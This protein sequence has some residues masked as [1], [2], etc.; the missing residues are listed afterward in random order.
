MSK[1]KTY[2]LANQVPKWAEEMI[3][4][5]YTWE[6][7]RSPWKKR[8]FFISMPCET[9]AAPLFALG[10]L[11][12]DLE[13]INTNNIDGHFDLLMR[14]R[15]NYLDNNID[16]ACLLDSNNKKFK[17]HD[18]KKDDVCL[19]VIPASYKKI[20]KKN[21]K[22][23]VNPHGPCCSYI[24]KEIAKHWRL[25]GQPIIQT[26]QLNNVLNEADYNLIPNCLGS[27]ENMNLS[28][29]YSGV[30]LIGDGKG[31]DSIYMKE[32]FNIIFC[33]GSIEVSLG[34]LLTL[35]PNMNGVK[36]IEFCNQKNI[37]QQNDSYKLII[38]DG[39]MAF[40]KSLDHFKNSD[41]VGLYSRDEP[42]ETLELLS[43]KLQEIKRFYKEI[44]YVTN[45]NYNYSSIDKYLIEKK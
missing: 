17:F 31:L 36:R 1:E 25:E 10:V 15:G 28:R 42:I 39:A 32:I 29:S 33:N 43:N 35:G 5:G 9:V 22:Q 18:V 23:I 38:A 45:L 16:Q 34:D 4:L 40:L 12:K 13:R 30:L 7:D 19:S 37:A 11:R 20:I 6:N 26:Q 2:W 8:V 21:N 24:T 44:N 14:A 41:V 3:T 27:I